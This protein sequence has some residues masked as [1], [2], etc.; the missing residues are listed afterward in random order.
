MLLNVPCNL[1]ELR[2]GKSNFY[3]EPVL[4]HQRSPATTLFLQILSSSPLEFLLVIF[5][6]AI[7][8]CNRYLIHNKL[9][10]SINCMKTQVD[11]LLEFF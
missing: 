9:S 3:L 10:G 2:L 8:G 7:V 4:F 6:C 11:V 1:G 5:G